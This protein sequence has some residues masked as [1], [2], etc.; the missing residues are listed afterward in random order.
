M[1]TTED[2]IRLLALQKYIN[3]RVTVYVGEANGEMP[4]AAT[5][6]LVHITETSEEWATETDEPVASV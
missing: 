2:P 6:D 1:I 4:T 3:H 5:Q